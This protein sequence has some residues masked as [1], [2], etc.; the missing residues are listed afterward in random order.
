MIFPLCLDCQSHCSF[1]CEFFCSLNTQQFKNLLVK[2]YASFAVLK[3]L[4]LMENPQTADKCQQI[5]KQQNQFQQ[6]EETS[7]QEL[8]KNIVQPLLGSG[9]AQHFKHVQ[10]SEDLLHSLCL[11]LDVNALEVTGSDGD[12]LMGIY[13]WG[14]KL[15]HNC[16]PNTAVSVDK[17]FHMK[18]YAAVPIQKGE[19][20]FNSYTNPMMVCI[21]K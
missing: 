13:E 6:Y 7:W 8:S 3:F 17:N 12:S 9:I 11:N 18:I 4:L 16:V 19:V 2:N 14:T 10:I 20:I 21:T 15:P 5:L 1:D